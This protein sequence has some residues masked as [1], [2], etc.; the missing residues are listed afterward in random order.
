MKV[1]GKYDNAFS[2][3]LAKGLLE[4][5]GI[6][7]YILNENLNYTTAAVNTDLLSIELVVNDDDYD[8]ASGV[9]AATSSIL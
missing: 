6:A 2:A 1:V 5:E 4:E 9:L 3:N 8:R 7:S